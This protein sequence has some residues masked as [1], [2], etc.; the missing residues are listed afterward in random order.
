MAWD[1]ARRLRDAAGVIIGVTLTLAGIVFFE[2]MLNT[3]GLGLNRWGLPLL[4][5]AV[6]LYI[7]LRGVARRG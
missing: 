7:L 3:S 5:I 4:L 6:G 1:S 2:F